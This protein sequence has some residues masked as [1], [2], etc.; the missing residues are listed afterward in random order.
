MRSMAFAKSY[1]WLL[2]NMFS[3]WRLQVICRNF[4]SS[5]FVSPYV[6]FMSFTLVTRRYLRTLL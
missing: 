5:F 1:F 6:S 2:I 4:S 3:S